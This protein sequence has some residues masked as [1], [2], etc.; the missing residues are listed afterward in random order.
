MS[1]EADARKERRERIAAMSRSDKQALIDESNA[2]KPAPLTLP[3]SAVETMSDA[4]WDA[5][6]FK[7]QTRLLAEGTADS[8]LA[9]LMRDLLALGVAD[10]IDA[11]EA[12]Q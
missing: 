4:E 6:P 8:V 1:K 10:Q 3:G 7:E 5:L 12:Q 9:G 2:R 11:F